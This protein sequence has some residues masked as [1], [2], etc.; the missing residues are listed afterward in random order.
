VCWRRKGKLLFL[1]VI[2]V[3]GFWMF[4]SF[5]FLPLVKSSVAINF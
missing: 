3:L 4:V 1:C 2:F 5:S